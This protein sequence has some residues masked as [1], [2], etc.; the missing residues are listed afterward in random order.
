MPHLLFINRKH[1]SVITRVS[2]RRVSLLL[3]SA[4]GVSGCAVHRV[5]LAPKPVMVAPDGDAEK[6]AEAAEKRREP[7]WLAFRS[8]ELDGLMDAEGYRDYVSFC[9]GK[10]TQQKNSYRHTFA[11]KAQRIYST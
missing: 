2:A 8:A 11:A 7:W 4:L 5:E 6:S 10:F 9:K 3:A 1:P